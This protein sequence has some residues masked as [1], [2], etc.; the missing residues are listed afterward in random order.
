MYLV[1]EDGNEIAD[2]IKHISYGI[3]SQYVKKWL[4]KGYH[5]CTSNV[6]DMSYLFLWFDS[7]FNP[8]PSDIKSDISDW[9]TSNVT[10]MSFMFAGGEDNNVEQKFNQD[11]TN[12]D[13]SKVTNMTSMFHNTP[14]F[15][16][17]LNN[18]DVN[19]VVR[20]CDFSQGSKITL[21]DSPY[22]TNIQ[23]NC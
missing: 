10:N 5:I 8:I 18:L 14:K 23:L 15:D 2:P 11:I 22:W 9:D 1:V 17:N 21:K 19:K 20:H 13:T 4:S 3:K 6:T 12:W 7:N 16:R